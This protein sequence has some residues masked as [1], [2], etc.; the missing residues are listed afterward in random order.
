MNIIALDLYKG[1]MSWETGPQYSVKSCVSDSFLSIKLSFPL[2]LPCIQR[3]L[4]DRI[5]LFQLLVFHLK[6]IWHPVAANA[7][8]PL[9]R[10]QCNVNRFKQTA[11]R[12]FTRVGCG[13]QHSS[14]EQR[15]GWPSDAHGTCHWKFP[16]E[17]SKFTDLQNPS[18][19][20]CFYSSCSFTCF[21]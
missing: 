17:P 20:L 14:A 12:G 3:H 1:D 9:H 7:I 8:L 18:F 5:L 19:S 16:R 13:T 11:G 2:H 21:M 15:E 10:E 4:H 6:K